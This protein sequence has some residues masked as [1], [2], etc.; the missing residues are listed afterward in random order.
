MYS[1]NGLF[2]CF[3]LNADL[4]SSPNPAKPA[5]KVP[6]QLSDN[7][8]HR[9]FLNSAHGWWATMTSHLAPYLPDGSASNIL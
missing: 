8:S 7:S 5:A 9:L 6:R 3:Q 2:N 1:F 4:P